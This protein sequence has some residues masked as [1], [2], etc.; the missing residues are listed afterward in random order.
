MNRPFR[1]KV[2]VQFSFY[3]WLKPPAVRHFPFG[4]VIQAKLMRKYSLQKCRVCE[5]QKKKNRYIAMKDDLPRIAADLAREVE[6]LRFA[7]PVSCIYNPL[8][9]AW[10]SHARYLEQ[11]GKGG[12]EVV[13]LGMNPGPWGMVQTGVPFGE[14]E[15]VRDWLGIEEPVAAPEKMHPKRPIDGFDCRRSEVSGKRLWGWARQRFGT[16]HKFFSRFFVAN[17]CPLSFMEESGRNRTPDKLPKIERQAWSGWCGQCG[18][19]M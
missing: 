16:P 13:F 6:E 18:P 2:Y 14:V 19:V 10:R 4:E 9:Y 5:T 3:R 15:L 8:R 1:T 12:R 11:Y 17:Y 7:P